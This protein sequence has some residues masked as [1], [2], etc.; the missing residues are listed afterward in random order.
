MVDYDIIVIGAGHSGCESAY[1]SAKL[2]HKTLLITL[3]LDNIAQ[4]SCNP[5]IGGLSKGNLVKEIDALGGI[6]AKVTDKTGIQFR[7]LNKKKGPAVQ[8][9]R[10]Q[11]DR[12]NYSKT[13]K[14]IL[15]N[16]PNLFL[17]QAEVQ[18]LIVENNS[19]KGIVTDLNEKIYSKSVIITA[20]TFLN[21]L[22]HIGD[23]SLLGGRISEPGANKLTDSI[24]KNG[25]ET[26]RLKTGTPPRL[27]GNSID[28]SVLEIQ[29]GDNPPPPFSFWTK[30]IKNKQVPCYLTYTN[31]NTSKII[32]ENILKSALYGGKIKSIGPRYCPSIEDKIMKFPQN[33]SHQVF[34][35][36]EGYETTEYYPSGLS[37]SLPIDVQY[38][39]LRTIKGL[40]NVEILRPGYAI[41]Y[42][43]FPPNQLK[44]TLES[45]II[46]NLFFAGQVNGTSGY[47]EAGAQGIISA[48][49]ASSKILNKE[50]LIL[51]RDESYTGVLIDDLV[52]KGT[53]EPYRMFTS[54]AEYRLLL[55]H[56]NT[57]S[58]LLKYAKKYNLLSDEEISEVEKFNEDVNR[59]LIEIKNYKISPSKTINELIIKNNESPIERGLNLIELLK[60]PNI[61]KKFLFNLD[62]EFFNKFRYEIIDEAIISIKYKGYIDKQVQDVERLKKLND[63]LIPNNI[64]YK[65]IKGLKKEAIEKLERVKPDSLGQALRIP[66]I[67]PSDINTILIY[68]K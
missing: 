46:S 37:T 54:R 27:D 56:T 13:M 15:E 67:T 24:I 42:D 28:F 1:I 59:F 55:R 63:K 61:D 8:S 34:L 31:E 33:N 7:I 38:K 47:E 29:Y 41:E 51:R 12:M 17:K 53:N 65:K 44:P 43:F 26:K 21:G 68:L 39:Y 50:P 6:M 58:R 19:V 20:G 2:G 48:I 9:V 35:E 18:E 32:K 10:A 62:K 25:I 45:K 23:I 52:T 5:S 66:G 22:I 57:H 36:P 30:E 64:D 11:T 49:N 60:R 14:Q 3:H 16:T 40:E 4:M